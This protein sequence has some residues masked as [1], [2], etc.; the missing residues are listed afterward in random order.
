M[1]K[2]CRILQGILGV[3]SGILAVLF[4][5]VEGQ[6]IV[7]GDWILHEQPLVGLMQ[8]ILRLG[9][10]ASVLF[11]SVRNIRG[12]HGNMREDLH[13]TVSCAVMAFLLPNGFGILF[14][15]LAVMVLAADFLVYRKC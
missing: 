5:A 6:K 10:S 8:F 7:C 4:F 11:S 2:C 3:V 12:K 1:K 15:L 14:L 13:I 9:I